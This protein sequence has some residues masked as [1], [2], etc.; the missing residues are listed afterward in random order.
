MKAGEL[1]Q[2][3]DAFR[4]QRNHAALQAASLVAAKD[5]TALFNVA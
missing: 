2:Q 5:S 1:K 4:Q 3:R